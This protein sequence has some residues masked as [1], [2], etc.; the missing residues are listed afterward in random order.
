[1]H[2]AGIRLGHASAQPVIGDEKQRRQQHRQG[3][4][5][6]Q[7]LRQRGRQ[8]ALLQRKGNQHKAEFTGLRQPQREQPLIAALQLEH[9]AQNIKHHTLGQHHRQRDAQQG[10]GLG[11]EAIDIQP[12]ADGDEKQPQ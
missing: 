12:R 10:K 6:Q 11:Q 1:M 2:F 4:G 9:L 3:G 5:G 8:N 7:G